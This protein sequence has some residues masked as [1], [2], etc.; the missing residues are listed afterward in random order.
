LIIFSS[1]N[2]ALRTAAE[3]RRGHDANAGLRGDKGTIYEGGHRVPLL[4]KWGRSG[5]QGSTRRPG[6]EVPGLVGV[7]DIYATLAQ[8]VGVSLN[9]DQG[10]DS[11]SLLPLLRG[12]GASPRRTMIQQA[13]RSDSKGKEFSYAY[14]SAEWKLI[15]TNRGVPRELYNLATDRREQTNLINSGPHSSLVQAMTADFRRD[16]TAPRTAPASRNRR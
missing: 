13:D 15:L 1:D 5:F 4:V 3:M 16:L 9:A 14:R 10:R 6:S 11:I 7:Q 8:L 12:T 2:G